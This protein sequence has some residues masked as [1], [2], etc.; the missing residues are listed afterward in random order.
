MRILLLRP[1]PDDL[2]FG[3]AP[4][5]QTEPLGL[6]YVAAV[7]RP[8]GHQVE[9]ADMR[10]DSRT[11][12]SI[13]RAGC[14]DL[15]AISCLH[16]LEVPA[17][18]RLADRIKACNPKIFVAIGGHAVSAYP[19]AIENHGSIDAICIGEG[20]TLMPRLCEALA[21]GRSLDTVP[22]LLLRGADG[23]FQATPAEPRKWVN[24]D[25]SPLPDRSLVARY[26]KRY[27]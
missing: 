22:S 23:K 7:I 13:V 11:I 5:F 20:E 14:P 12:D 24:F 8:L 16:I 4:F 18:L 1:C 2:R 26:Q 17:A 21:C 9:L 15:V 27:C 3:L 10:F 25:N 6:M 19:Q